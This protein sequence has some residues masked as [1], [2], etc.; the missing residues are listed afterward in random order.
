MSLRADVSAWATSHLDNQRE[1]SV[2]DA[3]DAIARDKAVLVVAH[4]LSAVE[5]AN[6]V[7]MLERG[8]IVERGTHAGLITGDGP[9]ARMHRSKGTAD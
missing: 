3:I 2:L 9:Y 1:E 4:R 7:V 8:R 5:R 6:H